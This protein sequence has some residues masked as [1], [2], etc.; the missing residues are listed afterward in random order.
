MITLAP[1]H[2]KIFV[3]ALGESVAIR[4]IPERLLRQFVCRSTRRGK[5]DLH[6]LKVLKFRHGVVDPNFTESEVETIFSKNGRSV[7][8][9]LDGIDEISGTPQVALDP[10]IPHGHRRAH[11]DAATVTRVQRRGDRSRRMQP[12]PRERRRAAPCRRAGSRRTASG[13]RGDPGE[14]DSDEPPGLRLWR[15]T[16]FGSCSP[17]ML[18]VLIGG[19]A[20]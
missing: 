6:K 7:D 13:A 19:A 10:R 12:R 18:R 1:S 8:L 5:L 4:P 14:S 3:P 15:H 9:I 2:R 11:Q 16:R 20:R 17:G